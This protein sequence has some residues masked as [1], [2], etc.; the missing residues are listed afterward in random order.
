MSHIS[1]IKT[2][3]RNL[4]DVEAAAKRLGGTLVRD[5]K[6]YRWFGEYVDD[7]PLDR[8]QFDSDAEY[9]LVLSMPRE[10][11]KA[12]MT[13]RLGKCDHAIRFPHAT[14][15]VGV[16][17]AKDG[18]FKLSYDYYGEGGLFPHM[19]QNGGRFSQAYA[20]EAAKRAARI[21]GYSAKETVRSDG[22]IAVE[23]LAR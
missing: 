22:S 20:V 7:T 9:S 23:L 18:T 10:Q 15:E 21:K 16:R 6:K 3:F 11:R 19:G 12:H 1:T 5:Q 17:K 14:Y 2:V 4:E 13:K 8:G